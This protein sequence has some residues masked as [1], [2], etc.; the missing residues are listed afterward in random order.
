[1][2]K[3]TDEDKIKIAGIDWYSTDEP[4]ISPLI[5]DAGENDFVILVSHTPDF[6]EKLK[7]G[8]TDFIA[9]IRSQNMFFYSFW[10]GPSFAAE[11]TG[12]RQRIWFFGTL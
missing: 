8:K 1:V 2:D 10:K 7:T 4:D 6:A 3:K 12:Y 9:C 5:K 11:K